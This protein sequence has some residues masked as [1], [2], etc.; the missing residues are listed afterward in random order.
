VEPAV[1]FVLMGNTEVLR[2]FLFESPSTKIAPASLNN[3]ERAGFAV[4]MSGSAAGCGLET[5]FAAPKTQ[6]RDTATSTQFVP[7]CEGA[8]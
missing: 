1:I 6:H 8:K 4:L 5:Q 3:N 7:G 2:H